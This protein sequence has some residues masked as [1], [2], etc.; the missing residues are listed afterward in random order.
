MKKLT[1]L[2]KAVLI[3]LFMQFCQFYECAYLILDLLSLITLVCP[4]LD[5][6]LLM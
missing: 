1:C 2:S 3:F 5:H 6:G 4:P